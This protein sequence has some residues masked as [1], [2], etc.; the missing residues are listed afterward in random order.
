MEAD[1]APLDLRA[2]RDLLK[3]ALL[4]VVV[5]GVEAMQE[6]GELHLVVRRLAGECVFAIRDG[7]GG[8]PAELRDKIFNLYFTTKAKG[9]GIGLA[10]SFRVVQLHSGTI[11]FSSET[12]RGTTFWLRFPLAEAENDLVKTE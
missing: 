6:G 1:P 11:D 7:G 9:S 12:G 5:N 4:N 3:Q 8:I 2:D 10:M